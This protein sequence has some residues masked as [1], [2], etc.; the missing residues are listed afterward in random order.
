MGAT[1]RMLYLKISRL[2]GHGRDPSSFV[3]WMGDS[4]WKE[5]SVVMSK[6]GRRSDSR[7]VSGQ[8]Q[9]CTLTER[10]RKELWFVCMKLSEVEL[11]EVG[12]QA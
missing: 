3:M 7:V 2:F 8:H 1:P 9:D 5:S 10:G 12:S 6:A 4:T 11:S